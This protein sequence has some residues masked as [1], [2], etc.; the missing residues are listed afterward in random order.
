M[1]LDDVNIS[2]IS[3]QI[4]Y[5]N[6]GTMG[7]ALMN[8]LDQLFPLVVHY[9]RGLQRTASIA[10]ILLFREVLRGN[11][12]HNVPDSLLLEKRMLQ[13]V[14]DCDSICWFEFE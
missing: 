5:N 2:N 12:S 4:L 14:S 1:L 9:K 6:L 3:D 8:G 13:S 7:L 10:R 11:Q